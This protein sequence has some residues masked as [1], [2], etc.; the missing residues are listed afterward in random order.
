MEI[1]AATRSDS[2]TETEGLL[3]HLGVLDA[4]LDDLP[5]TYP[6]H[7]KAV[8]IRGDIVEIYQILEQ[9]DSVD[10]KGLDAVSK[11][12]K[13]VNTAID[14]LAREIKQA[15]VVHAQRDKKE[16]KKPRKKS[17]NAKDSAP[18][19]RR[20][21]PKAPRRVLKMSM[22]NNLNKSLQLNYTNATI[23]APRGQSKVYLFERQ[24]NAANASAEKQPQRVPAKERDLR[25]QSTTLSDLLDE[26]ASGK[27]VDPSDLI[28]YLPA[29]TLAPKKLMDKPVIYSDGLKN[30]EFARNRAGYH[31]IADLTD[32]QFWEGMKTFRKWANTYEDQSGGVIRENKNKDNLDWSAK[33]GEFLELK[34]A[35]FHSCQITKINTLHSQL[36]PQRTITNI[37]PGFMSRQNDANLKIEPNV[38]NRVLDGI[39]RQALGSEPTLQHHN[40][41]QSSSPHH[42]N[43]P[44]TPTKAPSAPPKTGTGPPIPPSAAALLVELVAPPVAVPVATPPLP[45]VVPVT[46]AVPEVTAVLVAAAPEEVGRVGSVMV[47]IPLHNTLDMDERA[48]TSS[49]HGAGEYKKRRE[50]GR[51][52]RRELQRQEQ[53]EGKGVGG[54]SLGLSKYGLLIVADTGWGTEVCCC[55]CEGVDCALCESLMQKSEKDSREEEHFVGVKKIDY[56]KESI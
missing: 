54:D 47:P 1:T 26:K 50:I 33:V 16:G 29:N 43:S 53:F 46:F 5:L 18:V 44:T 13:A 28:A 30:S 8:A 7:K 12:I 6:E 9:P 56:V 24:E 52:G 3:I 49:S 51:D 42:K 41:S 23:D 55:G 39:L 21:G 4:Q 36:Q 11:N 20:R 34:D 22:N 10:E 19:A 48:I 14:C 27:L 17:R 45:D 15:F 37:A 40:P 31:H 25:A 32:H 2:R 35:L 38:P